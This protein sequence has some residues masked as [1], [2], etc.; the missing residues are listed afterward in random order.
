MTQ[1]PAGQRNSWV[2]LS[3]IIR[4]PSQKMIADLC[5]VPGC[6]QPTTQK[7]RLSLKTF[8]STWYIIRN[9]FTNHS[10]PRIQDVHWNSKNAGFFISVFER[11]SAVQELAIFANADAKVQIPHAL[12]STWPIMSATSSRAF[13]S[14]PPISLASTRTLL[15]CYE[16]L[17]YALN[18]I[19][20]WLSA[21]WKEESEHLKGSSN[22]NY[23]E[24][25]PPASSSAFSQLK[26]N[27]WRCILHVLPKSVTT[28]CTNGAQFSPSPIW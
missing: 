20:G 22:C 7:G 3:V 17:Q 18:E 8:N 28:T 5:A 19:Y 4:A 26:E 9:Q 1:G 21:A 6:K 2:L 10:S 14:V 25:Y 13:A 23:K 24:T 12:T 27:I 16:L 15:N 11:Y